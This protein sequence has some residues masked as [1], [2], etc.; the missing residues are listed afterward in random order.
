MGECGEKA[1]GWV[2][3]M[4]SRQNRKRKGVNTANTNLVSRKNEN[5]PHGGKETTKRKSNA[6]GGG[7]EKGSVHPLSSAKK[8]C[9]WEKRRGEGN[10]GDKKTNLIK[11]PRARSSVEGGVRKKLKRARGK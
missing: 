5:R 2:Q 8:A 1:T 3:K 7:V 9:L 4:P 11:V 10:P 6:L